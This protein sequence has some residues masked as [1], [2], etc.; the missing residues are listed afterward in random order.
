MWDHSTPIG[1]WYEINCNLTSH[2][3][4]FCHRFPIS[5]SPYSHHP[6]P[7][8][9]V[10][11]H[12]GGGTAKVSGGT[13]RSCM[14][15]TRSQRW[16]AMHQLQRHSEYAESAQRV[17]LQPLAFSTD[18][19]QSLSAKR[20]PNCVAQTLRTRNVLCSEKGGTEAEMHISEN[21][22]L[23]GKQDNLIL[24][25][26]KGASSEGSQ[27]WVREHVSRQRRSLSRKLICTQ[28]RAALQ[29]RAHRVAPG[30]CSTGCQHLWYT[31][32]S[33][34]QYCPIAHTCGPWGAA[35]P[36]CWAFPCVAPSG[37]RR[38]VAASSAW[39][40]DRGEVFGK[41]RENRVRK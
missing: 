40:G 12:K 20:E 26:Q 32:S 33:A 10:G 28:G 17:F 8:R 22:G 7:T 23:K 14:P 9:T 34:Q 41:K 19:S 18:Q 30:S 11:S 27:L 3:H 37:S 38:A 31:S 5:T 21:K 39:H 36:Q 2:L 4:L 24:G 1:T 16:C 13:N 6:K 25:K 29:H 15:E 35:M